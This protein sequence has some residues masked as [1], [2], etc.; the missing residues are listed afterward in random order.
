MLPKTEMDDAEDDNDDAFNAR[1]STSESNVGFDSPSEG[2][3]VKEDEWRLDVLNRMGRTE[4]PPS[5]SGT[6]THSEP[7]ISENALERER[8]SESPLGPYSAHEIHG[9]PDHES[10]PYKNLS[11]IPT[12]MSSLQRAEAGVTTAIGEANREHQLAAEQ[13]ETGAIAKLLPSAEEKDKDIK[14]VKFVDAI[15]RRFISPFHLVKTWSV[16]ALIS[17]LFFR[18]HLTSSLRASSI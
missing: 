15:G 9:T 11:P 12:S 10:V 16:C 17:R 4:D 6:P 14:F 2:S 5:S 8:Y 7:T 13:D 18:P 3:S 1:A